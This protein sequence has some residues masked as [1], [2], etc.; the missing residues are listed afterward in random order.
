MH[1]SGKVILGRYLRF[2]WDEYTKYTGGGFRIRRK[3]R[4][5]QK[6]P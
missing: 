6:L 1:T 4:R 3:P 2:V 5:E